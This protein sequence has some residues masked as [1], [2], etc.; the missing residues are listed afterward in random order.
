ME[1]WTTLNI[2][3]L[4]NK[5][6]EDGNELKSYR[7]LC[8]ALE[9]KP[10]GGNQKKAQ[11]KEL[12]RY[13]K[14]SKG[15]GYR[16]IVD[17][18]YDTPKPESKKSSVYG[19]IVQI[20]LTDF[21]IKAGVE[22]MYITKS[23]LMQQVNLINKNYRKNKKNAK[24]YSIS[25]SINEHTLHDFFDTTDSTLGGVIE[26]AL[27]AL[28]NKA[29]ILFTEDHIVRQSET[30]VYRMATDSERRV[31]LKTRDKLLKK[32]GYSSIRKI[33]FSEHQHQ[34]KK[35]TSEI[36][37]EEIGVSNVFKGYNI[38]IL[39]DSITEKQS[40]MIL[41]LLSMSESEEY[42]EELNEIVIDRLL[43][44]AYN[45]HEKVKMDKVAF[46]KRTLSKKEEA[47]RSNEYIDEIKIII[48]DNIKNTDVDH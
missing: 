8:N 35:E 46:G 17:E 30:S 31:I 22:K 9:I 21:F 27:K 34:Y 43:N 33:L 45:R 41:K 32:Y 14:L 19:G 36:L 40:K 37:K 28:Q 42:K 11:L 16:L 15:K 2:E 3:K 6:N 48:N 29:I 13:I 10:K 39:Q 20:L 1:G 5:I 44:N 24:E 23:Y 38:D 47:R 18:I 25:N 4:K 12:E 7:D 26:T